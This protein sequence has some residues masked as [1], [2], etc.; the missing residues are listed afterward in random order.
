VRNAGQEFGLLLPQS[1]A[2]RHHI[3]R[4]A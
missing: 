1:D 4:T 3:H 2:L